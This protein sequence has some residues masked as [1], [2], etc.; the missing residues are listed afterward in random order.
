MGSRAFVSASADLE[1]AG[2]SGTVRKSEKFPIYD[3]ENN[4]TGHHR[5]YFLEF[6]DK[7]ESVPEDAVSA[8]TR[9]AYAKDWLSFHGPAIVRGAVVWGTVAATVAAISYGSFS[10]AGKKSPENPEPVP[11]KSRIVR[12]SEELGEIQDSKGREL[13]TQSRLK[14]ELGESYRSVVSL[15]SRAKALEDERMKL[16]N[17]EESGLEIKVSD[18]VTH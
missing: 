3:G 13:E 4:V 6:G 10:G 15:D 5:F 17:P 8:F 11:E 9:Y 18:A 14:R 16:A 7:I 12:I 2:Q 1:R